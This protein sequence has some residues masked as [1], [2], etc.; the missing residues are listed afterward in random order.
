MVWYQNCVLIFLSVVWY[1][2]Y[3]TLLRSPCIF[4]TKACLK[5]LNILSK[6]SCC[7]H[8]YSILEIWFD[9]KVGIL[10]YTD[11]IS[12]FRWPLLVCNDIKAV[13]NFLFSLKSCF[14]ISH[15]YTYSKIG[16]HW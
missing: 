6:V 1:T 5:I 16:K 15:D 8:G 4:K 11:F 9:I 14:E 3:F 10:L 12:F 13:K 7:K 2:K